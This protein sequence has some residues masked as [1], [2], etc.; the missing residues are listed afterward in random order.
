MS[1]REGNC[2][3]FSFEQSPSRVLNI[4]TVTDD[5]P[6]GYCGFIRLT[7]TVDNPHVY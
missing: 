6:H 2:I 4:L 5:L 3:H 7:G 1:T